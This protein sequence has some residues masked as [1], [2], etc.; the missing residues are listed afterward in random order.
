MVRF[1]EHRGGLAD[2]LKTTVKVKDLDALKKLAM[3]L[4]VEA[5]LTNAT[6]DRLVITRL[7]FDPRCGWDTH[8]A[9]IPGWGVIGYTDGPLE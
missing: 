6:V 8:I 4:H 1:R 5:G 3:Q 2:S 7:V 9:Y